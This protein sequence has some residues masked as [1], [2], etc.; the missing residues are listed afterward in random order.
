MSR[1]PLRF[2]LA[3]SLVGLTA[4]GCSSEDDGL[5]GTGKALES[6]PVATTDA[7]AANDAAA[8]PV[9]PALPEYERGGNADGTITSKG[10]DTMRAV[11]DFW[12]E[13]FKEF[14]PNVDAEIESKGSSSAPAALVEGS[15][16]FGVMSR[17]M[18]DSE[19]Q[20]FEQK[21]GYPPTEIRT[22]RDLLAVFVNK[23][24]PVEGLTLPEVD[25]IFSAN[26]NLGLTERIE[27]WEEVGVEGPLSEASI[28][29]YGRNSASGTYGYFKDV[30]LGGGDF[31]DDVKEQPGTAGVVQAVSD[32]PA[33]IGYSGVGG[34]TA[35]VRTVPLALDEG[36][37]YYDASV[38]NADSGNY[39]LARFLLIYVNKAPD[40]DLTPL[41]Q[42]F[43]RYVFSKQGQEKVVQAGYFPVSAAEAAAQL[44]NAGLASE[45]SGSEDSDSA[46]SDSAVSA[47]SEN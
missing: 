3:L 15:A 17:P 33:A 32:D 26:R 21:F 46:E 42:E 10:S 47:S 45:D 22:S 14:Y 24:N 38:E 34:Q 37:E 16:L 8:V 5:G 19:I 7:E 23:D 20:K 39:P 13:G 2:L 27:R 44:E 43:L 11:M 30:A 18:K 9:D 12:T 4:V 6:D 1:P 41:Q 31:S 25:A 40:A 35:G 36:G 28:S 29:L